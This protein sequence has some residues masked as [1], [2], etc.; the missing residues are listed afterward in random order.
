MG[1][2]LD[3]QDGDD[4]KE[5]E[6]NRLLAES[7]EFLSGAKKWQW[8]ESLAGPTSGYKGTPSGGN[9][10]NFQEYILRGREALGELRRADGK[11]A[12]LQKWVFEEIHK[13]RILLHMLYVKEEYGW[14]GSLF[15]KSERDTLQG[16][17]VTLGDM[18]SAEDHLNRGPLTQKTIYDLGDRNT[19]KLGQNI[20]S[21]LCHGRALARRNSSYL[22]GR[23]EFAIKMLAFSDT[24][25]ADV[26]S[27]LGLGTGDIET[28][29][30][31]GQQCLEIGPGFS[32]FAVQ[33]RSQGVQLWTLDQ[34]SMR[35]LITE[36]D[37]W[38]RRED[39]MLYDRDFSAR[40]LQVM[41]E[42][43]E[44]LTAWHRKG[45]A[46]EL[47]KVYPQANFDA[48]FAHDS[49]F[50]NYSYIVFGKKPKVLWEQMRGVLESL[51][52]EGGVFC[53]S[54]LAS[55][56]LY[57]ENM[58]FGFMR[59]FIIALIEGDFEIVDSHDESGS[60]SWEMFLRNCASWRGNGAPQCLR[61]RRHPSSSIEIAT[62]SFE[63]LINSVLASAHR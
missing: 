50:Q 21:W 13:I 33:M 3:F 54:T 19:D 22:V 47:P 6:R 1:I 12:V 37:A 7:D 26:C 62:Q 15:S 20:A 25:F 59:A 10:R 63:S 52:P 49:V 28:M 32:D 38:T 57:S 56:L 48:I 46:A 29:E 4:Q 42:R 51:S 31:D 34:C 27:N 8:I 40:H 11:C 24:K 55:W 23:E 17:Q 44:E 16:F 18:L 41:K 9:A 60:F 30:R 53:T 36:F 58:M 61:I 2:D 43:E 45:L 5:A 14:G 39:S 35:E